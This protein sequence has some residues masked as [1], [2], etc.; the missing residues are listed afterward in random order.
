MTEKDKLIEKAI[1][2]LLKVEEDK[3]KGL[4][5]FLNKSCK[6]CK[7]LDE[8]LKE[9]ENKTMAK[10]QIRKGNK[11]L[12]SHNTRKEAGKKL[13]QLL[14]N[15]NDLELVELEGSVKRRKRK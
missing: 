6:G 3:T 1:I 9:F 8:L 4:H 13:G 11:I 10:F 7:E 5:K 2:H 14:F 15:N 12:S